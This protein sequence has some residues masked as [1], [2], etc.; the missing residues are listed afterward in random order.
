MPC[1]ISYPGSSPLTRGKPARAWRLAY[2]LGLI[3]AHAGKTYLHAPG[4]FGSRAH[5]RSR[6]ENV[7][8]V[9]VDWVLSGSSPLTR[10]KRAPANNHPPTHRLIPAHAGKTPVRGLTHRH[11]GAHPRSRGENRRARA[12]LPL[13][14]GSSPLTRG[15]PLVGRSFSMVSRLIPAHAGKTARGSVGVNM[16]GAH[17]RSRGENPR[18]SHERRPDHGLIPA[19][20]GKTAVAPPTRAGPPG[21]SPLTRGKPT[22]G[23]FP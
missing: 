14:P 8:R 1:I 9:L 12:G 11:V 2:R 6:G 5:P 15:K 10:G 20:A 4:S 17:P 22:S 3:P 16:T 21:S 13:G 7:K 18:D 19:H 23:I